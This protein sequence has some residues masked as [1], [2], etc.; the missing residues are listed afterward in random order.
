MGLCPTRGEGCDGGEAEL[1]VGQPLLP[2]LLLLL[3]NGP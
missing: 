2:V 3:V 1:L